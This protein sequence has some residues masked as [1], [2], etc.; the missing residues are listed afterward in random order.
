MGLVLIFSFLVQERHPQIAA[1]VADEIENHEYVMD[2]PE[3]KAHIVGGPDILKQSKPPPPFK[4][5]S[6]LF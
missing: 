1:E 2:E 3:K 4:A 6:F 5:L